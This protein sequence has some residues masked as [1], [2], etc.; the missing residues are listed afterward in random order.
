VLVADVPA[1][2]ERQPL[3]AAALARVLPGW[4]R[5]EVLDEVGSTNA[6]VAARAREDAAYQR[7]LGTPANLEAFAALADRRDPEFARI[8]AEHPPAL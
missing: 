2:V 5:L 6:V 4:A 3:D 7:L 8:D 1:G